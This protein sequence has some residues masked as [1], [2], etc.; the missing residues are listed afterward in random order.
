MCILLIFKVSINLAI[1]F[2]AKELK[3]ASC[4]F[5][6]LLELGLLN[7]T[8]T[9]L[10]IFHDAF[11][12]WNLIGWIFSG[13]PRKIHFIGI[14]LTLFSWV[15]LGYFYGLG[16]CIITDVH[17]SIK[18]C[19]GQTHLPPSYIQLRIQDIFGL[20][21]NLEITNTVVG[22]IFVI[23]LLVSEFLFWKKNNA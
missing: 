12:I 17:Y 16:Y 18:Y 8:D 9:S 22:I 11:T 6:Q 20:L 19:M 1:F 4:E 23:L 15:V 3:M 7:I 5:P 21:P 10:T 13:L 2:F 14:H